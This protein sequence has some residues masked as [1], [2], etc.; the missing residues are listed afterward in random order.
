MRSDVPEGALRD[1][2]TAEEM[3]SSDIPTPF[4]KK[5]LLGVDVYRVSDKTGILLSFRKEALEES[6]RAEVEGAIAL[7]VN[8]L[9]EMLMALARTPAQG[10][11]IPDGSA[12]PV[13]VSEPRQLRVDEP[14]TGYA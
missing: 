2:V 11:A 8:E 3:G 14:R 10:A 13:P 7:A 6:P 4:P 5:F 1:G 12:L 9:S